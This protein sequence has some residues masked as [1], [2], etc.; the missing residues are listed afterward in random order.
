MYSP[1]IRPQRIHEGGASKIVIGSGKQKGKVIHI[2]HSEPVERVKNPLNDRFTRHLEQLEDAWDKSH[3]FQQ[4]KDFIIKIITDEQRPLI[5]EIAALRDKE[6]QIKPI[7]QKKDI[8]IQ[9]VEEIVKEEEKIQNDDMLLL[10]ISDREEEIITKPT[11]EQEPEIKKE[12]ETP[13]K[14][15]IRRINISNQEQDET[16]TQ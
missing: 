10:D 4:V 16:P 3:S 13:K 9:T 2:T 7:L 12:A 11:P 15:R 8:E 5:E 14:L 1:A 6:T